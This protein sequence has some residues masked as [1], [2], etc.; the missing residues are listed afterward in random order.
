MKGIRFVAMVL[1]LLGSFLLMQGTAAAE[2]GVYDCIWTGGGKMAGSFYYTPTA[3]KSMFVDYG[4]FLPCPPMEPPLG[5]DPSGLLNVNWA[6]GNRFEMTNLISTYCW[7]DPARGVV[8]HGT[9]M[10]RVNWSKASTYQV[11]FEFV[12][13]TVAGQRDDAHIRILGPGSAYLLAEG[14]VVAGGQNTHHCW[15]PCDDE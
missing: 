6:N 1:V 15:M 9:G 12:N 7:L 13:A 14:Y 5:Y 11:E 3:T 2:R 4:L 10:G 8:I